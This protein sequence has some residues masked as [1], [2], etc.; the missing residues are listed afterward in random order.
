M[1]G[2]VLSLVSPMIRRLLLANLPY[3]LGNLMRTFPS[4]FTARGEFDVTGTDLTLLATDFHKSS[5][6]EELTGYSE[7]QVS[8]FQFL[9]KA[10]ERPTCLKTISDVIMYRKALL[11]HPD[12]WAAI[13]Q[14]WLQ[15]SRIYSERVRNA[16]LHTFALLN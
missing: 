1:V 6:L 9:Q 15:G 7:R 4:P 8:M 12:R 10:M 5:V 11:K 13:Q 16:L 14:L 3:E 2:M